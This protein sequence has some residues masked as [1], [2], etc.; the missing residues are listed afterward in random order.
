M[1]AS[2][3]GL[4]VGY[5]YDALGRLIAWEDNQGGGAKFEYDGVGRP[6]AITDSSGA[7]RRAKYDAAGSPV[8]STDALGN[9]ERVRYDES[10]RI[11]EV[12]ERNGDKARYDYTPAGQL[13]ADPLGV[14]DD[15]VGPE[16]GQIVGLSLRVAEPGQREPVGRSGPAGAALVVAM[17]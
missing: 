14:A 3:T 6:I 9:S 11:A 12:V 2:A 4:E 16:Q 8:E 7:T 1:A 15:V 10:G 13:A 17:D 5:H